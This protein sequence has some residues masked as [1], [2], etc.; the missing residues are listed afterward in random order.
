MPNRNALVSVFIRQ[1]VVGV[2]QMKNL[3][4]QLS[5]VSFQQRQPDISLIQEIGGREGEGGAGGETEG[6]GG[7]GGQVTG[8]VARLQG[9]GQ[10]QHE[11]S[12]V[13]T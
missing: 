12:V 9:A 8:V 3:V 2:H 11:G 10:G 7:G 13:V 5:L 6:G 1:I 4:H